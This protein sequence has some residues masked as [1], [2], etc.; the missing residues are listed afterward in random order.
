MNVDE[1]GLFYVCTFET[2]LKDQESKLQAIQSELEAA[3]D[4]LAAANRSFAIQGSQLEAL[5]AEKEELQAQ[6]SASSKVRHQVNAPCQ[7]SCT[8]GRSTLV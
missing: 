3:L 5:Q 4:S 7:S 2:I 6:L 1:T 8:L